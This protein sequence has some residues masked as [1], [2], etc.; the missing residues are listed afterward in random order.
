MIVES[1]WFDPLILMTIMVNCSTMAW[2][3]PLDPPG[4]NKQEILAHLEWVYLYIFPF[5]LC[6]KMIAYGIVCHKNS[7]LR[8]PWC[9]LDFV[10]VSLAWLPIIFTSSRL[11]EYCPRKTLFSKM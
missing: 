9:Q 8:D 7:Y 5:E 6:T 1:W 4:T 11:L 10:V 2:S 3:S